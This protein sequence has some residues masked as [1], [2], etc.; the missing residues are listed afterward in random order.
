MQGVD[1]A[2]VSN[3]ATE[4]HEQLGNAQGIPDEKLACSLH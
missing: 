1:K 2:E 4:A 3:V